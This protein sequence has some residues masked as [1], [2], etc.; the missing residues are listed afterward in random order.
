MLLE[1]IL[2]AFPDIAKIYILIRPKK[3]L[4]INQRVQKL[5]QSPVFSFI[6]HTQ[7]QIEKVTPIAG[8]VTS[9]NLGLSEEDRKLLQE[10]VS[11]VFHAAASIRFDSLL[12]EH[13]Q[14]NVVGTKYLLQLCKEMNQLACLVFCSTAF[15]NCQL[16]DVDEKLYPLKHKPE[17]VLKLYE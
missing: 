15:S 1:K 6:H 10:E 17:D 2:R 4:T 12:A 8:N 11:I 9:P 5:L 14:T 7:H 3:E 13:I 16:K